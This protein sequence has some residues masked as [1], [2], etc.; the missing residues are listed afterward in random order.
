MDP[1]GKVGQSIPRKE[2]HDK[3]SGRIKYLNDFNSPDML[4]AAL[5][6]SPRAHAKITVLNVASALLVPGVRAVLTGHDFPQQLGLYL[7]D[8]T[9]L[10]RGKVRYFGEPVAAVVA[11]TRKAALLAVEL[12]EAVYEPLEVINTL[13]DALKPEAPI[14]HEAMGSYA[15]IDAILPEP[16]TNV[17][18]RT[19]IRKGDIQSGFD[20]AEVVAEETFSFPPGDHGAMEVRAAMAEIMPNGQV[21]IHST[22]QAPFVVRALMSA[23]FNIEPGKITVVA[24]PIGGGY[25]GKAGIQLEG[26]AYLLSKSVG[27]RK[28]K[29]VNTREQ[30]L[31]TSPGH[32]GFEARVKL[33]AT[34][35][36]VFT[37]AE[38]LFHFDT[39]AYADYAV[40]ISRAAAVACTGPYR[41]PNV[42]CDS[43]CV[44]T[45]HPFATAYRGFG[46]VE[47]A[48]AIE[49]TIDILA[50]KLGMDSLKLRLRN[51]IKSGDTTPT[52]SIMD[53]NTGNLTECIKKAGALVKWDEGTRIEL[54]NGNILA[55]GLGCLWKAPA[56]PTNSDGGAIITFNEDGSVNLHCGAVEIGQGIKTSLA[57]ILAEKLD[58]PVE[59]IHVVY[60]VNTTVAPHDWATAA[61]RS[62]FMIGRAVLDAA[63]DAIG[64]IR[65]TA[66]AVLKCPA[67]DLSVGGGRVFI[68]DDPAI[69]LSVKEVALGYVYE[70]GTA[71]GGQVIGR[72]RYI[73]RRLTSLNPETGAGNPAL[74]WTLGA[75]AVVVEL[76]PRSCS[77]LILKAASVMDVGKVINPQIARG[78]VVG[79]IGMGLSF[80]S[81]EGFVFN[82]RG[83]TQNGD[84]RSYKL[85]RYGEQP[86][87]LIEF[88][89]TPQGDGPYGARGLGEQG[90]IGIPGALANALSRALG[91][92][93]N[94]LP[95]T[96]ESIWRKKEAIEE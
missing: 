62:L 2:S 60:E 96:P 65:H 77:Y 57:Q 18:N 66:S 48:F 30:D 95:L 55:K 50:D 94:Q 6:T 90:V 46:H 10:A 29:L 56:M 81:K 3:V 67:E 28:V 42:Y 70:D 12:I 36:G 34:R 68:K 20:E 93:L 37:S 54:E 78:Q 76:D 33:G 85:L 39:G 51:A 41:I 53:H 38:L 8:K 92:P 25:G 72:G 73:A 71:I 24:P 40:N 88:L 80:A 44:Y 63:E 49:R 79:S 35:D 32:I 61:S 31:L 17:A 58:I 23:Y 7:G 75:Q 13:Q 91:K 52:Q 21:I 59:Y 19:R 22:T 9:P 87:Y 47:F 15:H 5:K 43:L 82:E 89:E 74:E 26:L 4:H 45:N 64:Q 86:E 27:G 16:G 1:Y 84:L 14:L 69:G 11:D 83:H